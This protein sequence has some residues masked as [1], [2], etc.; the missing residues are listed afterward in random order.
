[1]I[2]TGTDNTSKERDL[3][4]LSIRKCIFRLG[5]VV[6]KGETEKLP[7]RDAIKRLA[8]SGSKNAKSLVASA[9]IGMYLGI[10]DNGSNFVLGNQNTNNN[11]SWFLKKNPDWQARVKEIYLVEDKNT[12]RTAEDLP[13]IVTGAVNGLN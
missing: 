5:K 7:I 8:P 13:P 12:P 2:T 3:G 10:L 6:P 1:M 11:I 9:K 4:S